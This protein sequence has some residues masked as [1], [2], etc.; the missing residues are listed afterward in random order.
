MNKNNF[1]AQLDKEMYIVKNNI[2][3]CFDRAFN[4]SLQTS[5]AD[6]LSFADILK[7]PV[8][9]HDDIYAVLQKVAKHGVTFQQ[10]ETLY[11][12]IG[13]IFADSAYGDFDELIEIIEKQHN[14]LSQNATI[15]VVAQSKKTE[16]SFAAYYHNGDGLHF[17]ECIVQIDA[18]PFEALF[19]QNGNVMVLQNVSSLK[20]TIKQKI[21]KDIENL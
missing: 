11:K 3:L 4:T 8:G 9:K 20:E 7:A 17:L 15:A 13:D 2:M 6:N 5:D 10:K 1:F 18:I 16:D 21:E 19:V 12:A 14:E